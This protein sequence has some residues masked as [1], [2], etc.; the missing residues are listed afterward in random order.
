[1]LQS[2]HE[3]TQMLVMVDYVRKMTVKKSCKNGKYGSL[4]HF[5]YWF[6]F[7]W[8]ERVGG[9]GGGVVGFDFFCLFDWL[10]GCLFVFCQ[11]KSSRSNRFLHPGPL[12]LHLQL[13]L[14]LVFFLF[15]FSLLFF[16]FPLTMSCMFV[17]DT[18]ELCM[19]IFVRS[20]LL[21]LLW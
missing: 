13:H 20:A 19:H 11:F 18:H 10:V 1:M 16:L 15:S 12:L 4:E 17:V 21:C 6:L 7:V 2:L 9:G 5:I 14:L 3:A 8:G